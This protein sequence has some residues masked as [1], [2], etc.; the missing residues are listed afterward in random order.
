VTDLQFRKMELNEKVAINIE[1]PAHVWLSFLFG[2]G[3]SEWSN[4]GASKIAFV[5]QEAMLDPIFLR[6]QAAE[7]QQHLDMHNAAFQ[8]LVTG[9]PPEMPPNVIDTPLFERPIGSDDYPPQPEDG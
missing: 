7:Q 6:E 5:V 9:H 3:E 4:M 1:L 8:H 2:Y